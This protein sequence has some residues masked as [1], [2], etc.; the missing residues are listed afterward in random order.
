MTVN[1]TAGSTVSGVIP[2]AKKFVDNNNVWLTR[3][4]NLKKKIP[5]KVA[6]KPT[7]ICNDFENPEF[8]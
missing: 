1:D 8:F 4:S 5:P 6:P 2:P 3:V 7:K